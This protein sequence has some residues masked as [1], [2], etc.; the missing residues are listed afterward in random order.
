MTSVLVGLGVLFL[1]VI[2]AIVVAKA[3]LKDY[4]TQQHR[5]QQAA[6]RALELNPVYREKVEEDRRY[7]LAKAQ[8]QLDRAKLNAEIFHAQQ[9]LDLRR[10]KQ[11]F[12]C[13]LQRDQFK[14]EVWKAHT[15]AQPETY[16]LDYQPQAITPLPSLRVSPK[17]QEVEYLPQPHFMQPTHEQLV[18][19][20]K[21]NSYTYSPG[22]DANTGEPVVV[23][24]IKVPHLKIIGTTGFGKSCLCG[25]IIDQL[26][27][28]HAPSKLQIALLDLEH[29]TSRL[30]EDLP[31]VASVRVN[32]GKR[33]VPMIATTADQ[34]AEYLGYLYQHM[35]YR[36]QL[37]PAELYKL[38]VM[39]IYIEEM[40][41]LT[42]EV[43][44]PKLLAMI[45]QSLLLLAVRAR[46]YGMFLLAA[47]Q[48]DYSTDQMKVNQ[49]MFRFRGAAGVDP[50]AARAAGFTNNELIKHNFQRG[51]PGQFVVE[52]PGFS[53]LI[54]TPIY[55]VEAKLADKF[56]YIPGFGQ[57]AL[58]ETP[59]EMSALKPDRNSPETALKNG[60]TTQQARFQEIRDL[61]R[62]GWG[63]VKIIEKVYD[64]AKPGKSKKYLAAQAEYEHLIAQLEREQIGA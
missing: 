20:I 15:F 24:L 41:A 35:K 26:T 48:T 64:G 55:D 43:I 39:L 54:L 29:K 56:G 49:K 46:K 50:S 40:L 18:S 11:H 22:I 17:P 8:L 62:A 42:Y 53:N 38:P 58:T 52:F 28:T 6:E 7:E 1:L 47:M 19:V 51:K 2:L 5:K 12:E 31:H 60:E 63:K 61:Y 13:L 10:E 57:T 23:D 44:D 34:V 25:S 4:R 14:L 9:E 3:Q 36:E 33:E 30:Y 45:F 32:N 59:P 16:I 27:T 37:P 21:P